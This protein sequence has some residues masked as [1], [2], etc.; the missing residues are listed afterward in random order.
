MVGVVLV[1]HV[2]VADVGEDAEGVLAVV[3]LEYV[4]VDEP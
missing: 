1:V 4:G 2:V 3:N